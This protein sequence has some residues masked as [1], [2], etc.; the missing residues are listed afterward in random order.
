MSIQ[1]APKLYGK[2]TQSPDY[3]VLDGDVLTV[4]EPVLPPERLIILGGGH[5]ALSVCIIGA[6]CGFNVCVV[7]DRADFANAQRFPEAQ[8]VICDD[9]S[10][11]I[12]KLSVSSF[13]YVVV[14]TQ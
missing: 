3:S 10:E 5:V 14:V 12:R 4:T 7:D 1:F 2:Q 13:D 6:R 9:F 8:T 11:A